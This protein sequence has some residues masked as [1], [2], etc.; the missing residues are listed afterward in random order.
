MYLDYYVKHK[1]LDM[2]QEASR[3]RL[4]RQAGKPAV[5]SDLLASGAELLGRQFIRLGSALTQARQPSVST[6]QPECATC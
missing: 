3:Q 6:L 1:M 5:S 4:V 2:Q